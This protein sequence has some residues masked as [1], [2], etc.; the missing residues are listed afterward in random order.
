MGF[1]SK[2]RL[3]IHKEEPDL[4]ERELPLESKVS[5]ESAKAA[6]PGRGETRRRVELLIPWKFEALK[7]RSQPS[8]AALSADDLKAPKNVSVPRWPELQLWSRLWPFLKSALG[9]DRESRDPD[10]MRC[11]DQVARLRPLLRLPRRRYL[12]W[13]PRAEIL[14]DRRRDLM[15]FRA[16]TDALIDGIVSARGRLGLR[17]RVLGDADPEIPA[18]DHFT[19]QLI[20]EPVPGGIPVLAV[21]DLGCYGEST[22]IKKCWIRYARNRKR[23]GGRVAALL[24]C[25]RDRWDPRVTDAWRSACWDRFEAAPRGNCGMRAQNRSE[26]PR[27]TEEILELLSPAVRIEPGLLRAVR[28]LLGPKHADVGTEFDVWRHPEIAA[29][30][31]ACGFKAGRAA[32]GRASLRD[33][34]EGGLKKRVAL[35]IRLYHADCSRVIRAEVDANLA[36][37]SMDLG[38]GDEDGAWRDL[39]GAVELMSQTIRRSDRALV[40]PDGLFRWYSGLVKR[41][42]RGARAQPAIGRGYALML[43]RSG[44]S[45]GELPEG[46]DPDIVAG[47]LE[48]LVEDKESDTLWEFRR[49]SHDLVISEGSDQIESQERGKRR[50]GAPIVWLTARKPVLAVRLEQSAGVRQSFN[51]LLDRRPEVE[52]PVSKVGGLTVSTDVESVEFVAVARPSWAHCF[53]RDRFGAY[54]ELDVDGVVFRLRWIPPG[55]YLMGSREE[56][57]GQLD[58]EGPRHEVTNA[59]GFWLAEAPCTQEQWK[60]VMGDEPSKFEGKQLPVETVSWQQCREFCHELAE[61]FPEL[62]FDLPLEAEWEYACRAG[63]SS[64]FSDGS[65]CTEPDGS[66]AALNR[67]G[68]YRENSDGRTQP[69]KG[70]AC[71]S[72]GLYD[73]HGNV[74]EWCLDDFR[75]YTDQAQTNPIGRGYGGLRQFFRGGSWLDLARFCR[76]ACR[77]PWFAPGSSS[78]SLGF[79]LAAGQEWERGARGRRAEGADAPGPRDEASAGR[80]RSGVRR[81]RPWAQRFLRDQFGV[82]LEFDVEEVRFALRWI[83]RG[84]FRMGSP[85]DERGRD[86]DEGPQHEVTVSRGFWLGV[87]PC[88]QVQWEVVMGSNPSDFDGRDRPVESVSWEECIKLCQSLEERMPCLGVRLPTEAEWEYACRAGTATAFNDGSPC[89]EPTGGDAALEELGWYGENSGGETRP[90][91]RKK[92]NAWDLHDMHG[93]VDEWCLDGMRQYAEESQTDPVGPMEEDARRVLRGGSWFPPA[94]YCRSA[95]RLPRPHVGRGSPLGFRLAAGQPVLSAAEGRAAPGPRDEASAGH[96]AGGA[97]RG[98]ASGR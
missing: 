79:R 77:S 51:M 2:G 12:S 59:S 24:P 82:L 98:S 68:W 57:A 42:S 87:T 35:L 20:N 90:V 96:P 3:A 11:V 54:A 65:D 61:R 1:E 50:K 7:P 44:A 33:M 22:S 36:E 75:E 38:G 91:G 21:G 4:E 6:S 31:L 94:R 43:Y 80:P 48:A 17:C 93:N 67:L 32:Q 46:T 83:P 25:P 23:C 29:T 63:T 53:G 37:C 69:V 92:P 9:E 95:S 52:I 70:K 15:P 55:R 71:N 88:T 60:A 81:A 47:T 41:L 26:H 14:F 30:A 56:E 45:V 19:R 10:Q 27:A 40:D 84:R 73:M 58:R 86:D 89:T 28:L 34:A 85:E 72:W 5:E 18:Y 78:P 8:V 66:D 49:L 97:R 62:V 76:S 64:A 39:E 13:A 74:W 16:D